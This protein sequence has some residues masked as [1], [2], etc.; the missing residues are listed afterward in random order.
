MLLSLVVTDRQSERERGRALAFVCGGVLAAAAAAAGRSPRT[1]S[2]CESL[3]A[4]LLFRFV[5]DYEKKERDIRVRYFA[6]TTKERVCQTEEEKWHTYVSTISY[7]RFDWKQFEKCE[8][9]KNSRC[10]DILSTEK[11]LFSYLEDFSY[12]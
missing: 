5:V 1:T 3:Q 4:N 9:L 12:I 10:S 6:L 7:N 11:N 8:R 2:P